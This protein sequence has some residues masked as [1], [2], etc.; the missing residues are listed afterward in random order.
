M[1]AL[2]R[3]I[4]ERIGQPNA[5]GC[6]PWLGSRTPDGYGRMKYQG[7]NIVAHRL[8]FELLVGPIPEGLTLDHVRARG[9]R[10]RHCVNPA[11]LE[12][13]TNHVN[14]MRGDTI[15]ARNAAKTHCPQGHP[16]VDSNIYWERSPEGGR[17][18]RCRACH[19]ARTSARQKRM[20]AEARA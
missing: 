2:P 10:L 19:N 18:R 1:T 5:D 4:A 12:P 11:H 6:W 3:T 17:R 16:Y 14:T 20:R 7:R 15:P 9:C 13:V 8:V